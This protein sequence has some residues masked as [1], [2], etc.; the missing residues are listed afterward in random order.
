MKL[1]SRVLTVV[2]FGLALV[3]GTSFA[4]ST[5]PCLDDQGNTLD[6]NNGNVLLWK[7]NTKNQT[8]KRAHIQGTVTKVYPNQTGHNHF[9]ATLVD[10]KN[11][12]TLEVIY[13]IEFGAIKNVQIGQTVEACGDYITSNANAGGYKASPDGAIIHWIHQSDNVNNHKNG[14]VVVN[15]VLYGFPGGSKAGGSTNNGGDDNSTN[16]NG[17]QNNNNNNGKNNGNQHGKKHH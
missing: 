14:Y 4:Q 5:P 1:T 7:V 8:L 12:G 6:V 15:N 17:N 9:E 13:N 3:S 16:N 11:S 2:V 10:G